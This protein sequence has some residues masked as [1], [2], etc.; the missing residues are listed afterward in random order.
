[1]ADLKTGAVLLGAL[2][3]LSLLAPS[4]VIHANVPTVRSLEMVERGDDDV[5]VI[6]VSHSSPS[7][8]H[9]IDSVEVQVGEQVYTIED[10]GEQSSSVFTVEHVLESPGAGVMVRAHCN[11][12]GWSQWAQIGEEPV[13]EGGDIPGFS[14]AATLI[15]LTLYLVAAHYRRQG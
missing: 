10:L 8:T 12:H 15:G 1:M 9:Y 13:D 11:I 3:T 6:E 4:T 7:S 14:Y 5:L 2:L